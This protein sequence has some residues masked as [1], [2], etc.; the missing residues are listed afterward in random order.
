MAALQYVHEPTYS[1]LILRRNFPDLMQP[2]GLIPTSLEWLY[3]KARYA[4][5]EHRWY[6]P[7]GATLTFGYLDRDQDKL[8]YQGAAFNFL[9]WDETSQ[10][11][12]TMYTW[13]FSRLRRVVGGK[14]PTRVRGATNPGGPGHEFLKQRFIKGNHPD[15]IF[16]PSKLSDN[17][18]LDSSDYLKTLANLDPITRQQLLDGNWDAIESEIFRPSWFRYYELANDGDY[19]LGNRIVPY[20]DCTRFMS[21]DA[22]GT[23]KKVGT[24]PDYTVC[25]VWDVTPSWSMILAYQWRGRMDTPD[26]AAKAMQIFKQFNCDYAVAPKLGGVDLGIYQT[27]RRSGMVIRRLPQGG[28]DKVQRSQMAQIRMESGSVWF[29]KDAPFT[30]ELVAELRM[31]DGIHGHDDQVD[32]LTIAA[33]HVQRMGGPLPLFSEVTPAPDD[34]RAPRRIEMAEEREK[35]WEAGRKAEAERYFRMNI[36]RLDDD[37]F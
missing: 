35:K 9:G 5:Q 30:D 11:L 10:F 23:E 20:R 28:Q 21:I 34:P 32:A 2:R 14:I 22:A 31:F 24:D 3:G 19:I 33:Q 13:M 27:L 12:D 4:S 29:P 17:P 36:A 18:H 25:Q 37:D 26:V 1:A 7:S 15:R 6:F 16:I 8:Q